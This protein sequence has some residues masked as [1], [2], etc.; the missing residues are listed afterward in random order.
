MSAMDRLAAASHWQAAGRLRVAPG[1]RRKI[2]TRAWLMSKA[3][4][5]AAGIDDTLLI[6]TVGRNRSLA[7]GY[8]RF[9]TQVVARN[10]LPRAD[11]ELVTLRTAWN[12]GC[13]YEFLHHAHLA[14]AGGL[15]IDSVER[16]ASGPA[17]AGWSVRQAALLTATDELND[18]RSISDA[19]FARLADFLTEDQVME[20]CFLIG[21]YEMLGMV[22]KT[23][24]VTPEPGVWQSGLLSWAVARPADDSDSLAPS[25]L[26]AVNKV[27]T[28]RIQGLWAPYLPP[29]AVI[30]HRGRTSGK[31]YR[32]PVTAFRTGDRLV[33][34]LFYG[35][36]A[37]W[38]RNLVAASQ[39]GA[40]RLGRLHRLSNVRVSDVATDGDLVPPFARPV[41]RLVKILVA[42][43][44]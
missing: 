37:D 8:L 26:P 20:L 35:D 11:V 24:G 23:A 13:W 44:T 22:I 36:R 28:N 9:A 21:H 16:I 7:R 41:V 31:E 2:G 40:E 34:P 19:T 6:Q 10:S 27:V 38:V 14:R 43:L 15:S 17:A 42:D 12:I 18:Q 32:T 33:V 5:W 1:D 4:G 39:G 29:Y 25:W 3:V 30:V